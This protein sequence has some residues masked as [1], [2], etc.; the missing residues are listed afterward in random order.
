MMEVTQSDSST[1]DSPLDSQNLSKNKASGKGIKT[2]RKRIKPKSG[3]G[4]GDILDVVIEEWDIL[5][6]ELKTLTEEEK[7]LIQKQ[8][9]ELI[10]GEDDL[11][12]IL[13]GE[14]EEF[15]E[16]MTNLNK[17]DKT[18]YVE[19]LQELKIIEVEY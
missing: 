6:E 9:N 4:T 17:G 13:F 16:Y 18:M 15:Q 14:K 1:T 2:I 7:N 11:G 8:L 12:S 5:Q 10:E 3:R 19:K